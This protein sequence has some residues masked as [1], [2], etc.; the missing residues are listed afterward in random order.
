M[1]TRESPDAT[2]SGLFLCLESDRLVKLLLIG[3]ALDKIEVLNSLSTK[4]GI[5][6]NA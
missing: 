2:A 1:S 4:L 6:L 5:L 3:P